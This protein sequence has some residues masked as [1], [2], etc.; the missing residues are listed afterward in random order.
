[1]KIKGVLLFVISA[2]LINLSWFYFSIDSDYSKNF[3]PK[4]KNRFDNNVFAKAARINNNHS[5]KVNIKDKFD[6]PDK[7][8]E[9]ERAIRT[10][11]G[12]AKPNYPLNYKIIELK[13]AIERKF[14][15]S[16]N[17][18]NGKYNGI[19]STNLPWIERGPG[20]VAG[21]T[22][23]L[24]VDPND[25]SGNTWFAA[26]V[27]GGVWKTT[28]EGV[29]WTDL[30]PNLPDLA[31]TVLA[32]SRSNHNI[33]Y[34]GTGE[35][36]Y[37]VD[38][39]SGDGIFKSTDHG[40]T[41]TQ[42]TSTANSIKFQNIN[43]II[44]SP[45]NPNLLLACTNISYFTQ[46]SNFYSGIFKSTDGGSS[47]TNVYSNNKHRVQQL[48]ANPENFNTLFATVNG[49]GVIKSSN[50]GESWNNTGGLFT[51]GR[52]EIAIAPSDTSRL[53][54]GA[55]AKTGSNL[56]VSED[57]GNT[58]TLA[59]D[60]SGRNP[61]WLGGQGWYGNTLAVNPF[62]EDSLFVGGINLYKFALISGTGKDHRIFA[63]TINTKSF[64]DFVNWGGS[65]LFGGG[66]IGSNF[67]GAASITDTDFVSVEL[68][69]GPGISQKACRFV[70]NKNGYAYQDY[71]SV[72]FQVWDVTHNRQ[73]MVSFRDWDN[74]GYFK[75]LPFN[76]SNPQGEYI[77]ISS[78]TYNPNNPISQIAVNNGMMYKNIYCIWPTLANG[79][80]WQP[81]N[82]PVS[83]IDINYQTINTKLH[84][85]A[86]VT[87]WYT[88]SGYPFIH[89]DQH[90]IVIIPV[91]KAGDAYRILDANDGGCAISN[92]E[93]ANWKQITSYQSTQFY[94]AD[95]NPV[96]DQYIGGMQDNGTWYSNPN[97]MA[98][99]AYNFAIG[100][101]GFFV[102]WKYD[103]PNMMLGCTYNDEFYNS[104][105]G[106]V[107]WHT[108]YNGLKDEGFNSPFITS[109][110]K[111]DEDPDLIFTTGKSGVWRSDN[112]GMYW[113]LSSFPDSE[114]NNLSTPVSISLANP[115]IVWAGAYLDASQGLE[116][117]TDGGVTFSVTNPNPAGNTYMLTGLAT[118]PIHDSTA[119]ALFS[120]YHAPKILKTTD[121]G[122]T[123]HDIS[124]FSS[125][126]SSTNGFPDVAT[127]CLMVMPNHPDTIWAGTEIG[128]FQSTDGGGTW[129]IAAN[130]LPSVS[131]WDMKIVGDE[132]VIATHGR[133]IW[134][135]KPP[136]L[137]GYQFP[138]VTKSPRLNYITQKP[139][140][141]LVISFSLRSEYDSTKI[142]INRKD[143]FRFSSNSSKIDTTI[144]LP[145]TA[146]AT[147]SVQIVSFKSGNRY[148]SSFQSYNVLVLQSARSSYKNDFN[149]A[150]KDFAGKGFKVETVKG[151][152]NGAIHSPHPYLDN[153]NNSFELTV[154]IKVAETNANLSYD[155]IAI[156]EPG[157][158]G[159]IFGYPNFYDYV[160]V[161]GTSDGITW[162]PL[163][164]GYDC[165]YNQAWLNAWNNNASGDSTMFVHHNID[166][167]KTFIAGQKIL[168]RFRLYADQ[169]THGWGWAIDNLSIQPNATNV[170]TNKSTL[171]KSFHLTQNYPN[172][173]NPSTSIN[174]QL[175]SSE[176]VTLIIYNAL[177][178]KVKTLINDIRQPGYYRIIWNGTNNMGV[179][180]ASGIYIYRMK[181]GKYIA[182]KKMVLL[183]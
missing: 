64:L 148:V 36:F 74:S 158:S 44:V 47:W 120:V 35:G 114:Y 19:Q 153:T 15:I 5:L 63:D 91:N 69:F 10:P 123:W 157:D 96:A 22:R 38:A 39:I 126:T 131:I 26:S 61:D 168:I 27:G 56:F 17:D 8:V 136:W 65:F 106:G 33:I 82:L 181:A 92:D 18:F 81:N 127:Y 83:K 87:N 53:Y 145:V 166:L 86:Q 109:L 46:G 179:N 1:M 57:A 42:L 146:A 41:W 94:G 102:D 14:G 130:G 124:G 137:S 20:N 112:F 164:P 88:G 45:A 119:Y 118:D 40:N 59:D 144:Y 177:G 60:S 108:A 135:V 24:I 147:D 140:G 152:N 150:T 28:N 156:V 93:G 62:Y 71:I 141:M 151:F 84:T 78:V 134:S 173:F 139:S 6:H 107:N 12:A 160:V 142:N 32:M 37:N 95:K 115:K 51:T 29:N 73:L 13:K 49:V 117:S 48:L 138:V 79:A 180:V 103:N 58:W 101:D 31:T 165:R 113:T 43:G 100:G 3:E 161:E 111:T 129:Q 80:V 170:E 154:P 68:R 52:I 159:S 2:L 116:V 16:L 89:A 25:P 169:F 174:F 132:V 7:F 162:L 104:S 121:L 178:Q 183:K 110:A 70:S 72:P 90:N 23:G 30:T 182:A 105:D 54:A 67:L 55:E 163:A 175:P 50:N 128:L 77:F 176:K 34:L 66:G 133:G 155:D 21:R 143:S 167:L 11:R 125:G 85:S 97:P 99:S 171:P 172:P 4:M 98:K 9:Y 122:K 149:S 76:N 75:L